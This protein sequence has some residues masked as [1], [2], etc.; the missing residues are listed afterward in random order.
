MTADLTTRAVR[1][2]LDRIA[3]T[4]GRVNAFT[5]VLAERA[6]ARAAR[7]DQDHDAAP[8]PLAGLTF[9]VKNLFDVAGLTTL[10]G[11][12]IERDAPPARCWWAR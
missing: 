2:S 11:S 4:D 6:L 10:A 3:A 1:Q 8:G 9:A 12:R 5:A 7:L